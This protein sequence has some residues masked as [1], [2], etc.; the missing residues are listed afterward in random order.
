VR[1]GARG[2]PAVLHP[3]LDALAALPNASPT[4]RGVSLEPPLS[5]CTALGHISVPPGPGGHV[6]LVGRTARGQSARTRLRLSCRPGNNPP[7]TP[8]PPTPPPPPP[9]PPPPL[10][11]VR[12][13]I[14]PQGGGQLSSDVGAGDLDGDGRPDVVVSGFQHLLWYHNP[15]WAPQPIADGSFGRGGKLVVRDLDG[16]GLPDLIGHEENTQ[17]IGRNGAVFTWRNATGR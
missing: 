6:V 1:L 4:G 9:P 3:L 13:T 2:T 16:D 15:D 14:D 10:R 7:V 8:P 17:V 5:G 12:E 11:F